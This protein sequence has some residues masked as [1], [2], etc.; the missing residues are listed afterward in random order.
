MFG[1]VKKFAFD[2]CIFWSFNKSHNFE[3]FNL[4]QLNIVAGQNYSSVSRQVRYIIP[5]K[6]SQNADFII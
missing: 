5:K 4:V 2:L 6:K 1:H 3:N